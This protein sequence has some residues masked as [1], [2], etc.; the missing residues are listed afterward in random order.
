VHHRRQLAL[1]RRDLTLDI[2][3]FGWWK[4]REFLRLQGLAVALGRQ[5]QPRL[6]LIASASE[7][8]R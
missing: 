6:R 8:I 7:L 1:D 5:R 4:L 3:A 2:F